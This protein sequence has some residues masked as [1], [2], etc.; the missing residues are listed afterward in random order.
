MNKTQEQLVKMINSAIHGGKINI[1]NTEIINWDDLLEEAKAHSVIPLIYSSI[2]KTS[3]INSLNKDKLDLLKKQVFYSSINQVRHIK[4]TSEILKVLQEENIEVIV[5]K[6]LIV[7][8]LYPNPDLRTMSDA[9]IIVHKEDLEKVSEVLIEMNYTQTKHE[10]EHGAHIVFNKPNSCIEVHW[11]LLNEDF[12]KGDKSFEEN[13][14][15]N[16]IKVKV[17]E[18]T[19]LSLS[20]EDL[21]AHLCIHMASHFSHK[22]FGVRQLCDL[23]LVVEKKGYDINWVKFNEKIRMCKL[24]KFTA[25]IFNVCQNLFEMR[26]PKEL[27]SIY[28][29]N[30]KVINLVIDDIFEAGVFGNK[31]TDNM[32]GRELA[33]DKEMESGSSG[34]RIIG[35]FMRLLF[36]VINEMNDKYSYAKKYKIL[37]PI[38]WIHHLI[39]GMFNKNY[40][41][42]NKIGMLFSTITI[43]SNRSKLLKKLEL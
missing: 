16:V 20:W 42:K 25:A 37:A 19:A 41:T 3:I 40:N 8:S 13:L 12:F 24:E 18:T 31:N 38:A 34:I 43:S 30:E 36:P 27:I 1:D 29:I 33:F 11:T 35:R 4:K 28:N 2:N 5:L 10:D 39:E 17:G 26:I 21:A 32:F 6:G 7:R 9:D 15:N 23:V 22:G 14:W